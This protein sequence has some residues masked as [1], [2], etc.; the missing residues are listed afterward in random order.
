MEAGSFHDNMRQ[1]IAKVL[2]KTSDPSDK[3]ATSLLTYLPHA[4]VLNSTAKYE[5]ILKTVLDTGKCV[6]IKDYV[7]AKNKNPPFGDFYMNIRDDTNAQVKQLHLK[8][9]AI[10]NLNDDGI[11]DTYDQHSYIKKWSVC[12]PTDLTL[13][14]V[15]CPVPIRCHCTDTY[16]Y[17]K[18]NCL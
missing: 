18:L 8:S 11:F 12:H 7:L 13:D 2:D 15:V 3:I 9:G 14:I 4:V 10:V 16:T 5:T 17:E 6:L 1:D